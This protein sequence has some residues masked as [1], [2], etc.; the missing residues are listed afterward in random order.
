M[1]YHIYYSIKKKYI[2]T[3]LCFSHRMQLVELLSAYFAFVED[4]H[5]S[6][7]DTAMSLYY[8]YKLYVFE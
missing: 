3:F 4:D 7:L 5:S 1:T 8:R 2:H 6:T